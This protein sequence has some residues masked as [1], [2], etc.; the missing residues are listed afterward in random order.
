MAARPSPGIAKTC[1]RDGRVGFIAVSFR[2]RFKAAV[3]E[4]CRQAPP[5][6]ARRKLAFRLDTLAPARRLSARS[7]RSPSGAIGPPAVIHIFGIAGTKVDAE[8]SLQASSG[9]AKRRRASQVGACRHIS[10]PALE[11][12]PSNGCAHR[13]IEPDWLGCRTA[14]A[15]ARPT[16][17]EAGKRPPRPRPPSG[18]PVSPTLQESAG[19]RN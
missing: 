1:S 9:C 10:T 11:I 2:C 5:G 8:G 6:F 15:C 18:I 13:A 7:Q 12:H 4:T 17:R 16:H 3:V 14:G 19:F